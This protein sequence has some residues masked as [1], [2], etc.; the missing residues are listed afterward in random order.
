[1]PA[2][3][4]PTQEFG[5]KTLRARMVA[6]ACVL[7]LGLAAARSLPLALAPHA[8][9]PRLRVELRL[10]E[11]TDPF[12]VTRKWVEPIEAAIRAGGSIASLSGSVASD[13]ASLD[14]RYAAGGAGGAVGDP[15][16]RELANLRRAA[17]LR[18]ELA[19]LLARLPPA[20][21]L[22]VAPAAGG[23]GELA[24]LLWVDGG[25]VVRLGAEELIESLRAVPG[26]RSVALAGAARS[27]ITVAMRANL[28]AARRAAAEVA[29]AIDGWQSFAPLGQAL[30]GG[31][32]LAVVV[33]PGGGGG[34]GGAA[35]ALAALPVTP[36]GVAAAAQV[37][38]PGV[39]GVAIGLRGAV[40]L[41]ALAE[42]TADPAPPE[43]RAHWHG[44]SGCLLEVR[45]EAAASPLELDRALLDRLH[46]VLAQ[47][48]SSAP[49]ARPTAALLAA[50]SRLPLAAAPSGSPRPAM[51]LAPFA[52]S[53]VT[54]DVAVLYSEAAGLRRLLG[55]TAVGGLLAC[56][57]LAAGGW[58][59][60][61]AVGALSLLALLPLAAAGGLALFRLA[62]IPLDPPAVV[63]LL[64]AL[65]ATA[66][67]VFTP[68]S[69]PRFRGGAMVAAVAAVAA[70]AAVPLAAAQAANTGD[71]LAAL[72]EPARAFVLAILGGAAAHALLAV[73]L[74]SPDGLRRALAGALRRLLRDP[75][76]VALTAV[77]LS[78]AL[79]MACGSALAFQTGAAAAGA[80]LAIRLAMPEGSDLAATE[81]E[82]WRV[83]GR[84][85]AV[86]AASSHWSLLDR[87]HATVFVE[88]RDR[89]RQPDR[90]AVLLSELPFLLGRGA[91]A[92]EVAANTG[93]AAG[94]IDSG[95]DA[96]GAPEGAA[97]DRQANR[98]RFLLRSTDGSGLLEA[99]RLIQNR[100]TAV[101]IARLVGRGLGEPA[102]R[103]EIDLPAALPPPA[104]A[105]A[106]NG[107]SYAAALA[108]ALAER[109]A[110]PAA[111]SRQ[112]WLP[113]GRASDLRLLAARAPRDPH[114][115][116]QR[117]A[118]LAPPWLPGDAMAAPAIGLAAVERLALSEL[119]RQSG[120]FVAPFEAAFGDYNVEHRREARRKLDRSLGRLVLP[121]GCALE[122]PELSRE[123]GA[124][125]LWPQ[126]KS[127]A[128][129]AVFTLVLVLL[130]LAM[131]VWRLDSLVLGGLS[132]VPAV[133]GLA[134][135]TP[136]IFAVSGTLDGLTLA[137]LAMAL[138]G[139]LPAAIVGA[140]SG[141][142]G[143]YVGGA[144]C[145]STLAALAAGSAGPGPALYRAASGQLV[146]RLAALAAALPLLGVPA[147][148]ASG[149]NGQSWK[150][151][152]AAGLLAG[153][154]SLLVSWLVLPAALQ[155]L[156]AARR[157]RAPQHRIAAHPAAWARAGGAVEPGSVEPD[158]LVARRLSR[159]YPGGVR[160]LWRV[161]FELGPGITGL[162]GPNG[163]GKT[164]LLRTLVGLQ[165][166]TRGTVSFR[167]VP[168]RAAN[169]AEYR[170]HVGFL[171]Q[172]LNAYPGFSAEQF[173]EFWA[174]ERGL[175]QRAERRAEVARLLAAVGL[176]EHATRRVRDFSGGMRKRMGFAVALLGNPPVLVVDEPTT[177]LDLESRQRFRQALLA[178]AGDRII[179]F[180]T[181]LASDIEA[182]AS[183]LLLLYRG[184]L[185]F[186]GAP[187]ALIGQARGRVFEAV[188]PEDQLPRLARRYRLA[189]RVQTLEGIR[190][191]AVA[192]PGEP[193]AG[194]EVDPTLEEAYL[195]IIS[196]A[197]GAAGMAAVSD[198]A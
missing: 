138:A 75:L 139:A 97:A 18:A 44:R 19:P 166:P 55:A 127:A 46:I 70:A 174:V 61:G 4:A 87:G 196:A 111:R 137:A 198:D 68:S 143:C 88:L 78:V 66:A 17:R 135:A 41:D 161:S 14:V 156:A 64:L 104:T 195:A 190:V 23:V 169:L 150:A 144:A 197:A 165:R 58:L 187:S 188:V 108:S 43:R 16:Q 50:A 129:A 194:R 106:A 114:E 35:A 176:A 20:A 11:S 155:L 154:A 49:L 38:A 45:R 85:D 184:G 84:L 175:A 69:M 82:A 30:A 191:R 15:R 183:R 130:W 170:R 81:A 163:A 12:E 24:T 109:T 117:A 71:E 128:A 186:D 181:H 51:S 148:A 52:A 116:R 42:V 171:P 160:A 95:F 172:E 36:V 90:L 48:P 94:W 189:A 146:G 157:R 134:V 107:R 182:T 147:L 131:G 34:A 53:A 119:P 72:A 39:A 22:D 180:S 112:I 121:A 57:V 6:A 162:L 29:A 103:L 5:G 33:S 86:P 79:V 31:R 40:R 60:G 153:S 89:E 13:G 105:A 25:A 59:L 140:G 125:D 159:L 168:V 132:L 10:G 62:G 102:L 100:L 76:S 63:A 99:L 7:A 32:R 113:G 56:L 93:I 167:G 47:A 120:Q 158:R 26:V 37:A 27:R 193:L 149:G 74:R 2:S 98:Y 185:L 92:I 80:E 67:G 9:L 126:G 152:L 124:L 110:P 173:L 122:R 65:A 91:A 1:M 164:T 177:G 136:A 179:V 77:S 118:V 115:V 101:H 178:L 21:G 145:G 142:G 123:R 73:P 83:E 3:Q 141:G 151:P 28:P 8:E 96:A 54:P 192:P 133:A